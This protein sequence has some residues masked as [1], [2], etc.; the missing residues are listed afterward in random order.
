M[1]AEDVKSILKQNNKI[2]SNVNLAVEQAKEIHVKMRQKKRIHEVGRIL[3]GR[4]AT[5]RSGE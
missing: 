2:Y 5:G 3:Q 4:K 1:T